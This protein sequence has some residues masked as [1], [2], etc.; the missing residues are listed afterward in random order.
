[1]DPLALI[2]NPGSASRKYAIYSGQNCLARLHFE[3]IGEK[4]IDCTFSDKKGEQV[5]EVK[6]PNLNSVLG[7][8]VPLLVKHGIIKAKTDIT[9][10]GIRIVAPSSYFLEDRVI[11]N[12]AIEHLKTLAERAPLHLNTTLN[13]IKLLKLAFPKIKIIAVSDSAFHAGKP[14]FA[15]NYG[16]KLH[17]ADR[18]DI[19][20]FGYHGL[21]VESIVE[22][23]KNSRRLPRKLLVC[24][25][26]GG[27]SIT[28]VKDGRSQDN[29]MGY[30][31]LDGPIM[32]TRSGSIDPTAVIALKGQL[33]LKDKQVEEYLNQSSGLMGLS[34][35][36]GDVRELLR[37][38]HDNHHVALALQTYIYNIQ[39]AVGQMAA[40][41]DGCDAIVF[42][43]TIGVRSPAVR[44]RICSS[45]EYLGFK[46]DQSR[47]HK[48]T[49]ESDK[50]VFIQ[51]S[52]QSK[53]IY[54]LT[55]DESG[56]IAKHISKFQS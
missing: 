32:A 42:T 35:V 2:S 38:E 4:T 8:V 3:K 15:W 56:Q 41:L 22:R 24:H 40:V 26:G 55:T 7:S 10:I 21:S 17:D 43:G 28:A 44:T 50:L 5:F 19:K 11:D 16:L 29:T 52:R 48:Y 9:K 33:G 20:R 39:K 30:T 54:V 36:T 25:L 23:L 51:D 18:F 6:L 31:P 14:D 37:L 45:L 47:N 46:I 49:K 34:G 53:P 12:D 1:M 27:I 13:E